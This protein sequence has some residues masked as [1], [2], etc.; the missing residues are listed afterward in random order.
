MLRCPSLGKLFL[1][2]TAMGRLPK[3]AV[4]AKPLAVIVPAVKLPLASRFTTVLPVLVVDTPPPAKPDA[5][6]VP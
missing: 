4:P 2:T 5:S 6:T 1:P 3:M